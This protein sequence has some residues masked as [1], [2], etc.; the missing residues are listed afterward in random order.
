MPNTSR[1]P[2]FAKS[3]ALLSVCF[4][5][6]VTGPALAVSGAFVEAGHADD[7]DY[8]RIGLVWKPDM[9]WQATQG[10]RLVGQIES[11]L[12]YW[13]SQAAQGREALELSVA[14][15]ARY[16][17]NASGGTQPYLEAGL[18]AHLFSHRDIDARR[19]HDAVMQFSSH[20]GLGF[21]FGDRSQYDIAYR[22][23][24]IDADPGSQQVRL[25]YVY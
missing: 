15:T 22:V 21:T 3:R 17:P 8:G 18:G 25:T 12:G 24:K 4:G 20:L 10:W 14:P 11:A 16:R 7:L 23:Q 2:C 9:Q 6:A 1:F 13:K 19:D 5:L